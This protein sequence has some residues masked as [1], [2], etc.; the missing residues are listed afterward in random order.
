MA[1]TE[2]VD[3]MN[4]RSRSTP[5]GHSAI[6]NFDGIT[7]RR[8]RG[9]FVLGLSLDRFVPSENAQILVLACL[10]VVSAIIVATLQER[11]L[12]IPGFKYTG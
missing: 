5:D 2:V 3:V 4:T 8:V 9:V 10:A 7:P 12:Y 11:V 6:H 1:A